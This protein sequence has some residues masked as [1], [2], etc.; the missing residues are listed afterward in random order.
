MRVSDRMFKIDSLRR[1]QSAQKAVSAAT[2]QLST[3]KEVYRASED[4]LRYVTANRFR[5]VVESKEQHVRNIA[6]VRRNMAENEA[7]IGRIRD[8]LQK[9]RTLLVQG[10][11]ET[12][13]T[14]DTRLIAADVRASLESIFQ[15]SND[16]N[17][18]G[19]VFSGTRTDREPFEALRDANGHITEVLYRGNTTARNRAVAEGTEVETNL[20]GSRFFQVDPGVSVSAFTVEQPGQVIGEVDDDGNLVPDLADG[21]ESGFFRVQDTRIWFNTAEDSLLDIAARINASGA[22]ARAWVRGELVGVDTAPAGTLSSAQDTTG[23]SAGTIAINGVEITIAA[24]AT[25]EEVV[26]AINAVSD[27]TLVSAEVT[28]VT[29]GVALRL[30]GGAII[31]D[32]GTGRSDALQRL[33]VTTGAPIPGNLQSRNPIAY[34]LEISS[35]STDQ[36]RLDDEEANRFLERLGM[37]DGTHNA[38]NN[39]PVSSAEGRSIFRTLIDAIENLENGETAAIRIDRIPEFDRALERISA[40]HAEIGARIAQLD[41]S[42]NREEEFILQAKKTISEAVELDIS[43]AVIRLQIAQLRLQAAIGAASNL[44]VSSLLNYL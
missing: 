42:G 17:G 24:N 9:T 15:F 41:V 37:T 4:P 16:R 23:A 21:P 6:D 20:V 30:Q 44:P 34:Q 33:G 40:A 43:D 22:D 38:P 39:I 5:A 13:T 28:N 10:S 14:A 26:S 35:A 3:G 18:E 25:L 1:I 11:S 12:L 7:A 27:E 31:E 36:L 2:E 29:G 19:Y 8:L 32:I